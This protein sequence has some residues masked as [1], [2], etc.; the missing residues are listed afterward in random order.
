MLAEAVAMSVPFG[1][2]VSAVDASELILAIDS[3]LDPKLQQG[4]QPL[5]SLRSDEAVDTFL[6][7]AAVS[8]VSHVMPR[9]TTF[10]TVG[11]GPHF[12]T[13]GHLSH[14]E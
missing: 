13:K 3:A 12:V 11:E 14:I 7:L 8:S 2:A 9:R 6:A 5:M 10:R 1:E 4:G